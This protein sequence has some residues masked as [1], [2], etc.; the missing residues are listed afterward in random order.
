MATVFRNLKETL[1]VIP[2]Q[3]KLV[4]FEGYCNDACIPE[5]LRGFKI[6][7]DVVIFVMAFPELSNATLASASACFLH[8]GTGR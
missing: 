6:D 3:R 8:P 1:S 5:H 4:L 2:E 7:A